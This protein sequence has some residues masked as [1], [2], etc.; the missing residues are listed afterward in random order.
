MTLTPA[1][2]GLRSLAA[3]LMRCARRTCPA[4]QRARSVAVALALIAGLAGAVQAAATADPS[5]RADKALALAVARS[6]ADIEGLKSAGVTVYARLSS[7]VGSAFLIGAD[8][9]AA[10]L[11]TAEGHRLVTLD[12]RIGE[13]RYYVVYLM[14]RPNRPGALDLEAYGTVL[15]QCEAYAVMRTSEKDAERLAEAGAEIRAVTFDPKPL[16]AAPPIRLAPAAVAADPAVQ[17]MIDLVD[18]AA[19]YQYTGDLSGEWPVTVGGAQYTIATRHTF[20]GTPIQKTTQFAGERMEALGLAVEYMTWDDP[21]YPNV[22]G[23]LPGSV[24]PDTIVI[25]CGHIDDMPSVPLAPGADDNA[26]GSVAVLVAADVLSRYDWRYTLRFAL[27]TGEEQGLLG[28]HA[29]AQRSSGLGEHIAGVL[30]LDMIAYNTGGSARGIDLH[31]NGG[32]PSTLELAQLFAGVV[33]AYGIAL[34]PQV[35][36]MGIGSSDHASFCDYG[37]TAI[38][39]IEDLSDFNPRYHTVNDELQ[40]LDMG[41]YVEFVKASVATCAHMAGALVQE[42]AV[43]STGPRESILLALLLAILGLGSIRARP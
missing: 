20:S 5:P 39:G 4:A 6:P 30:N 2:P 40:Y 41:Y 35:V 11:L 43:P 10:A 36:P 42:T 9:S 25:I 14:P 31:A 1:F 33:S 18:S 15:Y 12:P 29:Y 38:L 3:A 7:A 24:S 23:E 37:Y 26:S 32:M 27:W 17:A 22:I 34:I 13:A 16:A 19:V 21:T 28:S 8:A